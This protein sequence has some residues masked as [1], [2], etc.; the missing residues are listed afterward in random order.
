MAQ[1]EED[2]EV[3]FPIGKPYE[4]T[5]KIVVHG[6]DS[7]EKFCG[8]PQGSLKNWEM[9]LSKENAGLLKLLR[10]A[11]QPAEEVARPTPT[12]PMQSTQHEVGTGWRFHAYDEQGKQVWLKAVRSWHMPLLRITHGAALRLGQQRRSG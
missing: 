11:C 10:A 4:C 3:S 5:E 2:H 6:V 8:L 12:K 7:S 1:L 9:Q